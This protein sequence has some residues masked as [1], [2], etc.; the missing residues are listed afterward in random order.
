MAGQ[1]QWYKECMSSMMLSVVAARI[2]FSVTCLGGDFWFHS[3]NMRTWLSETEFQILMNSKQ[4]HAALQL[5]PI[6][7]KPTI[8]HRCYLVSCWTLLFFH[9]KVLCS[10]ISCL[11]MMPVRSCTCIESPWNIGEIKF[12]K[13]WGQLLSW[14][15]SGL[16]LSAHFRIKR[17]A[18][19]LLEFNTPKYILSAC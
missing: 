12:T 11:S 13:T 4:L 15:F 17:K 8:C 10:I 3:S 16:S 9:M 2:L 14:D 18:K 7:P 1:R 6:S 5:V 19:S